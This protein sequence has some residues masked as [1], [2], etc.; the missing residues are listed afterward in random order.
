MGMRFCWHR[1]FSMINSWPETHG[2][3]M[4]QA[5]LPSWASSEAQGEGWTTGSTVVQTLFGGED[6]EVRIRGEPR[7]TL[8]IST[9]DPAVN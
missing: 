8:A 2:I 3:R 4:I 9:I 6:S 7:K 1:R 5:W